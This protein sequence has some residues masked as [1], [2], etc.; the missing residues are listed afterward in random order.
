LFR[1]NL[2]QQ[3]SAAGF[4]CP[5]GSRS[6]TEPLQNVNELAVRELNRTPS[7]DLILPSAGKE[8]VQEKFDKRDIKKHR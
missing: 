8:Y 6:S 3:A 2:G 5:S 1:N 4:N 7:R